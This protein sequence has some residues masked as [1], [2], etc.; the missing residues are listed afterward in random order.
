MEAAI[1][2]N[3]TLKLARAGITGSQLPIVYAK[4]QTH[5]KLTVS[6][7]ETGGPAALLDDATT[8]NVTIKALASAGGELF[9]QKMAPTAVKTDS[10]EF[11]WDILGNTALLNAIGNCIEGIEAVLTIGWTLGT[12][13][14]KVD[15]PVTI[16]NTWQRTTDY[17]PDLLPFR[18]TITESGYLRL[19]NAAGD[20]FHIGLNTGEP[21]V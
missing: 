10:Y 1:C 16:A 18:A 12:R 6:F 13:V 3:T 9:A 17:G 14:E 2:I 4:F 19:V 21:P 5:L 8:F 11:E 15:I 20:V 7:F